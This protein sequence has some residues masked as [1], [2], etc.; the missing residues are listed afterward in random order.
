MQMFHMSTIKIDLDQVVLQGIE[1]ATSDNGEKTITKEEVEKLLRH[2]TYDIFSEDAL[3]ES[4]KE[5]NDFMAQ[6]IDSILE[7]RS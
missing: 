2:G 7:R 4:E 5:L 6:D 1:N 3:G